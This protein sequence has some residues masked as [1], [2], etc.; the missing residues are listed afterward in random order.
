M[1]RKV[2]VF[3]NIQTFYYIIIDSICDTRLE[4]RKAQRSSLLSVT[5]FK[6]DGVFVGTDRRQQ[7][8]C[9]LLI[10]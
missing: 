9:A 2:F 10:H 5:V 6:E 3:A 1:G 4:K 7:I 8:G